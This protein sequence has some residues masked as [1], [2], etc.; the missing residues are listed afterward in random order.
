DRLRAGARQV[1]GARAGPH[2]VDV[3]GARLAVG[4]E[5]DVSDIPQLVELP[6]EQVGCELVDLRTALANRQQDRLVSSVELDR[7]TLDRSPEPVRTYAPSVQKRT[8]T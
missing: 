6:R 3:R 2:A 8:E 4:P 5:D 1:P 7:S